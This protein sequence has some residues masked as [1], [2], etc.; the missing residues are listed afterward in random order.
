MGGTHRDWHLDAS[1]ALR[2]LARGGQLWGSWG[3]PSHAL[4]HLQGRDVRT[5]GRSRARRTVPSDHRGQPGQGTPGHRGEAPGFRQGTRHQGQDFYG[6]ESSWDSPYQAS[7]PGSSP[8]TR[9]GWGSDGGGRPPLPTCTLPHL[10]SDL[11]P[12]SLS[13]WPWPQAP[14]QPSQTSSSPF[15][16]FLWG[17]PP[18]LPDV[19]SAL[20]AT[21]DACSTTGNPAGTE[22]APARGRALSG[23]RWRHPGD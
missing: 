13:C 7:Q 9:Q 2:P 22:A 21:P 12:D 1:S 6:L 11:K 17:L 4:S 19:P 16:T 8:G 3:C 18:G 14:P 20:A 15:L 10:L 23:G 5:W